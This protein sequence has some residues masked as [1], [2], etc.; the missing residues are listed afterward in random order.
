MT[1]IHVTAPTRFVEA[2]GTR[3]AY[4]RFGNKL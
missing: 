3:Y 4:R 1:H 2:S